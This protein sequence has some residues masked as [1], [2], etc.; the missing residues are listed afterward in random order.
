MPCG[1]QSQTA[2]TIT[3]W[4]KAEGDEVNE[5]DAVLELSTGTL[6]ASGDARA[7]DE[8]KMIVE[9]TEVGYVGKILA[10]EGD[11]AE[12]RTYSRAASGTGRSR[13]RP[14]SCQNIP[15]QC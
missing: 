4:L 2:G 11:T 9:L 12:V 8:T 7:G 6:Y 15:A 13:L 3:K 10:A 5:Y 14:G 1:R